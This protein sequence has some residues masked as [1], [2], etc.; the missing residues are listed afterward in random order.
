MKLEAMKNDWPEVINDS[1]LASNNE[2]RA[3]LSAI[4]LAKTFSF[5]ALSEEYGYE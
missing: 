3:L 5:E 2:I 4:K 1:K